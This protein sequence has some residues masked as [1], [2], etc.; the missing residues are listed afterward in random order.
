[1]NALANPL[2]FDEST[3]WVDLPPQAALEDSEAALDELAAFLRGPCKDGGSSWF[4]C[5]GPEERRGLTP[6]ADRA[7]WLGGSGCQHTGIERY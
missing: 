7:A 4:L 6:A 3:L 2:R 5:E 1:M